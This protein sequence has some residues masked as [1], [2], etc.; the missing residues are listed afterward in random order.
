[1]QSSQPH[2]LAQD[3]LP[4]AGVMYQKENQSF[5]GGGVFVVDGFT[6]FVGV[7]RG[8]FVSLTL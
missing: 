5:T 2:F 4:L 7:L 8:H 1:M 3:P 6:A